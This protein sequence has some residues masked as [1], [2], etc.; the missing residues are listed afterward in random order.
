MAS[1]LVRF[2]VQAPTSMGS[3]AEK[4]VMYYCCTVAF[5]VLLVKMHLIECLSKEAEKEIVTSV[6]M[7]KTCWDMSALVRRLLLHSNEP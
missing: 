6:P 3:P 1:E 7:L 4:I 5:G 2:S